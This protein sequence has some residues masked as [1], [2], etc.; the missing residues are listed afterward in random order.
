MYVYIFYEVYM[1]LKV[2][3]IIFDLNTYLLQQKIYRK[4]ELN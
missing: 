3:Y 4:D 1:Y 2:K